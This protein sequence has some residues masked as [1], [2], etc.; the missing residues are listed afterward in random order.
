VTGRPVYDNDFVVRGDHVAILIISRGNC[1]T[2]LVDL[3]DFPKTRGRRWSIRTNW[4]TNRKHIYTLYAVTGT[5]PTAGS[6][7]S[8]HRLLLDDAPADH[9]IDHINGNGLDNRRANLRAVSPSANSF[10]RTR[11]Q[12]N[13]STGY[14]GVA[15]HKMSGHFRVRVRYGPYFFSKAGYTDRAEA[16]LD[17]AIMRA[18]FENRM[19]GAK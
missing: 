1:Y 6:H 9:Q 5:R 14:R 13:N 18:R 16:G 10:N 2:C 8:I 4:S 12:L 11:R 15:V 19:R 3:A 17:A 7:L